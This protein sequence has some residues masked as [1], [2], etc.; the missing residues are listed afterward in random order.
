LAVE[1]TRVVVAVTFCFVLE[2]FRRVELIVL[3]AVRGIVIFG[4]IDV[5]V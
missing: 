3:F 5:A 1:A 2:T 4:V